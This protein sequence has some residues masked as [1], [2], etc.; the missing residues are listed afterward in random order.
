MPNREPWC[1]SAD[2][3]VFSLLTTR[4]P[5]VN[6]PGSCFRCAIQVDP[7]ARIQDLFISPTS[8]GKLSLLRSITQFIH[9]TQGL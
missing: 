8:S 4:N 2:M 6:S 5:A 9:C 1:E 7:E 3:T